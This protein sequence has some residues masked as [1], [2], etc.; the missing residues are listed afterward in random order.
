MSSIEARAAV[1]FSETMQEFG[2]ARKKMWSAVYKLQE[3]YHELGP[4][5]WQ[6]DWPW[7]ESTIRNYL[8]VAKAF[9]PSRQPKCL[10]VGA[11]QVIQGMPEE[12]RFALAEYADKIAELGE[13]KTGEKVTVRWL[14]TKRLELEGTVLPPETSWDE[15][16]RELVYCE[17]LLRRCLDVLEYAGHQELHEEVEAWLNSK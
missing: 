8:S 5:F 9:P 15:M 1:L 13:A 2:A 14:K 3:V 16:R 10:P 11:C 6:L 7:E 4:A 12:K 17:G